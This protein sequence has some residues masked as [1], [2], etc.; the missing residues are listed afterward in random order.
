ML[1]R[2]LKELL[3]NGLKPIIE[4]VDEEYAT[5]DLDYK[6]RVE[7]LSYSDTDEDGVFTIICD[8]KSH[9]EYNKQFAKASYYDKQGNPTLTWFE[10]S[11]YPKD[12]KYE[13]YIDMDHETGL[14][15]VNENKYYKQYK[16]SKSNLNYIAWLENLVDTYSKI[17]L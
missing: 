17:I 4:V 15:I 11:F 12:E 8:L 7:I 9:K 3:N 6:M 1:G 5:E 16:A 14:E 2:E 13:I 10:T